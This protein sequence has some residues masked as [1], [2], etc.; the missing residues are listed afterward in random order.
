MTSDR[1]ELEALIAALEADERRLELP[2]FSNDDAWELGSALVS[3]G[4]RRRLP[5][6]IDIRR[7]GQQ[8]FHAALEGTTPSN[9]DWVARK[10]NVVN[11][12]YESSYLA[13]RRLERSGVAL[14]EQLGVNPID[15][16]AHGGAFPIRITGVGVVG[17]I[18][19]SGLPQVDDHA[20]VVEIL[21][22]FK[23]SMADRPAA[24]SLQD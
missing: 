12:F 1:A 8:L 21:T 15:V 17:T 22:Q 24:T 6:T 7:H 5:I 14:D 20:L 16:A 3:A 2:R 13:G 19:V 4:R 9:D 18:T 10:I 23:D 11:R